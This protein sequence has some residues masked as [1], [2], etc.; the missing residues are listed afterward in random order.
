MKKNKLILLVSI[1]MVL[2]VGVA[3]VAYAAT[4]Y[5][6]PAEII[7]GLTGKTADEVLAG[8]Q[9]GN[10]FGEQ[11]IAAGKLEE[12]QAAKLE[13]YKLRLDQAVAD[14]KLTQ[15]QADKLYEAM[16]TR[17][18]A[19]DGTCTND[20]IRQ[21]MGAG[22]GNGIGGGMMQ[23]SGSGNGTGFGGGMRGMRGNGLNCTGTTVQ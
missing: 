8:R 3:S 1:V 10:S 23:R 9:A 17:I 14:G 18:A 5:K 15:E 6:T 20:G 13:N 4:E 21:G 19:C 11:A 2:L 7:A 16:Q 22:S 12:F